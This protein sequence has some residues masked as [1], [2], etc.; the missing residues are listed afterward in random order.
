[1]S[2]Q[3]KNSLVAEN[4]STILSPIAGSASAAARKSSPVTDV[5]TKQP[6][7]PTSTPTGCYAGSARASRIIGQKTVVYVMRSSSGRRAAGSGRAARAQG[8]RRGCHVRIQGSTSEEEG[9]RSGVVDW[10]GRVGSRGLR[11]PEK[12][13]RVGKSFRFTPFS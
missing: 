7:I 11:R 6:T 2:S 3:A 9:V 1:M 4:V 5:T 12:G 13:T 10:V 8:I